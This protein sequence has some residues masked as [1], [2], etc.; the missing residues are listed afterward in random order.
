MS[1]T[2]YPG[3]TWHEILPGISGE[4]RGLVKD[5][6]RYESEDRLGAEKVTLAQRVGLKLSLLMIEQALRLPYFQI[7]SE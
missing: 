3:K 6:V 7:A 4:A 1:F 5:L 2:K